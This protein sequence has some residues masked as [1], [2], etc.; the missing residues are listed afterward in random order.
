MSEQDKT[1][2]NI[3]VILDFARELLVG[4]EEWKR[5]ESWVAREKSLAFALEA[6]EDLQT[7]NYYLVRRLHLIKR[8][9]PSGQYIETLCDQRLIVEKR[10]LRQRYATT[11][12]FLCA[13]CAEISW[14]Q[15]NIEGSRWKAPR[16]QRKES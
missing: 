1:Y 16:W 5:L 7:A 12:P 4:P 6:E 9:M 11:E 3:Q 10:K 15:H 13:K 14:R 8:K 2:E